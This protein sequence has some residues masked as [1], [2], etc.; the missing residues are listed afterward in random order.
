MQN[1]EAVTYKLLRALNVKAN[2]SVIKKSLKEHPEYPSVLAI[3]DCLA[4]YEVESY[5]Y[6]VDKKQIKIEEL[7]FPFLAHYYDTKFVFV[8]S[9]SN[10]RVSYS[11]EN[12]EDGTMSF[13]ELLHLWNG[14]TFH[15]KPNE[16]SGEVNYYTN[17]VN[18][19]I[20]SLKLPVLISTFIILIASFWL[21]KGFSMPF[22]GLLCTKI[23]GLGTA[24]FLIAKSLNN[25]NPYVKNIC[26]LVGKNDCNS[27]LKSE[28][29]KITSWLSWSDVGFLY[30]SSTFLLFLID[31]YNIFLPILSYL[32][33]P[34]TVYSISYQFIKKQWCVLCCLIQ[35]VLVME[36][37]LFII[38]KDFSINP[39]LIGVQN[40]VNLLLALM[41]PI[42]I[43]SYLRPTLINA[44][45]LRSVKRQ[46]NK[47]K[48]NYEMF[49]QNLTAQTKYD[50]SKDLS[51]ISLGNP[52]SET[53]LTI[54]SNPFCPPCA[55][56][57]MKIDELL[58]SRALRVDVLFTS[59][60]NQ[61]MEKTR[62][63]RHLSALYMKAD[64]C[65]HKAMN[66]WYSSSKKDYETWALKYPIVLTPEVDE[67]TQRQSKWCHS[68]KIT[69]TPT[70]LINGYKLPDLYRID[71]LKYLLN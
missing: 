16:K 70:V 30:F 65:I 53:V 2:K 37:L 48:Y 33:L 25:R 26:S 7:V 17:R 3:S 35:A 64:N 28:A 9:I 34:Y 31:P 4:D 50:I 13:N 12:V 57:H 44:Q 38:S 55:E 49:E 60:S 20:F 47:F 27:I 6:R 11:D 39:N 68:V 52:N 42:V 51:P 59:F 40:I 58:K 8:N 61:D 18:S 24:L 54:I 43:W 69:A 71:D 62:V 29:A 19:F 66:D 5:C 15:A 46:L 21:Q 10:D 45:Q 22:V 32:A 23:M 36:G 1:T 41:V 56:M 63:S 14:I 67:V